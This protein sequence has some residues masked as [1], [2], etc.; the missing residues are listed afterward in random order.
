MDITKNCI[1]QYVESHLQ[2]I[3]REDV[4]IEILGD[5]YVINHVARYKAYEFWNKDDE[6]LI[7]EFNNHSF[8]GDYI[9]TIFFFLSG[10][11]EYT[12]NDKKDEYY[13]FS[14]KESFSYKKGILEEPVVDILVNRISQDLDMEYN[15]NF[16]K[17]KMFLTHDIDHIGLAKGFKF[18]RSLGGDV[19][20]R[21]DIP[22]VLE[23]IK[24]KLQGEDPHS[25][26]RL[27][28]LHKKYKTKGTYFFLPGLQ[29]KELAVGGGY[30]PL[31]EKQY[32]KKLKEEILDSGS[33]IGIHYDARHIEEYRMK[34]DI[35]TLE[36]VFRCSINTGRAHY[37][38]F[39]IARSFDIYESAGIKLDTTCS[40]A[41]MIGFRFGTSYPFKP[42]NFKEKREYNFLEVPLIVMEGSLQ[43]FKYMNLTPE[44]G[45]MKIKK[46]MDTV[47]E[48][49][50]IFT[51]LWHNTSFFTRNWQPWEWVYEEV[52]KYGQAMS[53]EFM[54]AHEIMKTNEEVK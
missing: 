29:S 40:Y 28:A 46:L 45:L 9:G 33:S 51:M 53:F 27:I 34:K 25:A 19:L 3:F 15:N 13:R 20:R 26:G 23:K 41:D 4:C 50:G 39:D 37:L 17:S 1:I 38:I 22:M 5:Y 21:R 12:H 47:K 52:I 16:I 2:T 7:S 10:Y 43:S 36:D 49:N 18:L 48:Y 44:E 42:Y 30:N 54:S 31:K 24:K 32:L 11:W 35:K 8:E 14:A 6:E